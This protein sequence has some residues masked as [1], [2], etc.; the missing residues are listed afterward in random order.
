MGAIAFT[1]DAKVDVGSRTIMPAGF[2]RKGWFNSVWSPLARHLYRLRYGPIGPYLAR[3]LVIPGWLGT[4]EGLALAEVSRALPVNATIVEVGSFLGRSAVLLA[5]ARKISGSGRVCCVDP[6][7]ASGD[8]FSVPVYRSIAETD[9][10]SLRR[11]FDAN[12]ADAGLRDWVEVYEGTAASV[13][14]SWIAPIDMLFLDGDQSPGGAGSAYDVWA[15]F[16]KPGG[17]V[18]LHNSNDRV[19][20]LGHDG[21]RLL[22]VHVVKPPQYDQIRC[23]ETTTFG[24]KLY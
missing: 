5:G 15:P 7:D 11:R 17:I 8:D 12:I 3:A 22:A 16:L 6:F 21:H 13:A 9:R 24:R 1:S 18:A 10:R 19:Y 14:S 4:S 23:V 20:A 2:P